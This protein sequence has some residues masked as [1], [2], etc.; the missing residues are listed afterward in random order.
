MQQALMTKM[1]ENLV[2]LIEKAERLMERIEAVLPKPL[3]EP[4]WS[5]SVAW[6]FRKRA[7]GHGAL[8]PVRHVGS[9]ALA[10]VVPLRAAERGGAVR[11]SGGCHDL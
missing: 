4:D 3:S 5:Q 6:R 9:I 1:N 8:E 11:R 10:G 2:R 7:S